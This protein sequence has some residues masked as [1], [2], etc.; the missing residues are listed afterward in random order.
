[1]QERK[2]S[3]RVIAMCVSLLASKSFGKDDICIKKSG[4]M[5]CQ[6]GDVNLVNTS[7][8][9][10]TNK[11]NIKKRLMVKGQA[12]L[13]NTQI[14]EM[15][16]FGEAVLCDTTV[17]GRSEIYGHLSSQKSKFQIRRRRY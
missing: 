15:K 4:Q 17:N 8:V 6:E 3:F 5:V 1:M 7:G 16:V 12:V 9:L 10:K 2:L 14:N 11:T 13:N